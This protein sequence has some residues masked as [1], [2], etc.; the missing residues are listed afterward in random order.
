MKP[1]LKI[2]RWLDRNVA[3]FCAGLYFVIFLD[4]LLSADWQMVRAWGAGC[5]WCLL[6][7]QEERRNR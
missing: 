7:L 6:Y 2:F 5:I 3:P 4:S 1:P